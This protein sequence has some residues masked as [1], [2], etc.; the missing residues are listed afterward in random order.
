MAMTITM[1]AFCATGVQAA[2][3]RNEQVYQ[4]A[5]ANREEALDLLKEIVDIDSGTGDVAG[6]ARVAAVLAA[7][8]K[9]LG[10]EVR[11]EP[12]EMSG[13]PDNLVA[14]FR[15]TGKGRI[16]I[17]AHFDTVFG[18]GTAPARPFG[19]D[20]E[21]AHGPGVGDEKA[22]VVNA[23]MALKILRDLRF[24]NYQTIT[25]L[26]DDSEERGSPGSRKL[27]TALVKQHDVEF[28]MEPGDPPDALTVWRKGSSGI[29][30]EVKGRAA[31]AGM[32]PQD[33]RNAAVELVHQLAALEGAFPHSGAG[34]TVNLTV[35]KSG[36]RNNI[37]PDLAQATLNV[38]F[39][40]PEEFNAV[41]TK[42]ESGSG[43][44]LVA[45]TKVTVTHDAAY[46]PLTENA[47][48]DALAARARKIYAEIG[49]TVELS[50]NGGA[51]E[52]ALAMAE[53]TPALDGL[54]YVGGDFHTDHE[55]IDLS[56]VV[57]RL[58]L[59]T[60]L[61]MEVGAHP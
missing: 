39:R 51:S 26:L 48:I 12:A 8:L 30:I 35:L 36:E 54:G 5:I 49:K 61:L 43:A 32:A 57:P 59:F 10:G 45:D 44:T 23:V 41:L 7:R 38:R 17:I 52:S 34:T 28:N 24:K 16:L 46:P 9:A 29:H 56:S 18:P 50:G 20:R 53:G 58:Y 13:L 27:I 22:G 55:W 21:R 42:V 1:T 47:Q 37:I 2:P 11:T 14:V 40:T 31:H 25:L 15:G 19:M 3:H 33:G 4:A 6:G 60:R